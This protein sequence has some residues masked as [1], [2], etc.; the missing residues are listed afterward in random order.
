M[1]VLSEQAVIEAV[2]KHL[3]YRHPGGATLEVLPEG[4]RQDQEWWYVPIRPSIQ[5]TRRYEYYET[6]ADVEKEVEKS[7]H[8]TVLLVPVLPD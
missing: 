2:E 8:L 1:S 5:P 7:D 4:I 6:L 3:K